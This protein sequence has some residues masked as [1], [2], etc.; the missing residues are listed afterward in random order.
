MWSWSHYQFGFIR[1]GFKWQSSVRNAY[2]MNRAPYR[3]RSVFTCTKTKL[4][5]IS[6]ALAFRHS[7]TCVFSFTFVCITN[8]HCIITSQRS[9]ILK[10]GLFVVNLCFMSNVFGCTA[11]KLLKPWHTYDLSANLK[12]VNDTYCKQNSTLTGLL[13]QFFSKLL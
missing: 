7:S 3:K 2:F 10:S 11:F 6:I 5:I 4:L 9:R 1:N 8:F 13:I 12:T